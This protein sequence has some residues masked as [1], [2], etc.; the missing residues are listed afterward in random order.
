MVGSIN[1]YLGPEYRDLASKYQ[2]SGIL[3]VY[4]PAGCD[5]SS[6][7]IVMWNRVY[8]GVVVV[9]IPGIDKAC[10]LWPWTSVR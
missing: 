9:R 1:N 6:T 7:C 5:N 3:R 2:N 10:F 4:C 8:S